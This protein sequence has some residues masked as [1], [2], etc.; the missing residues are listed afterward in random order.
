MHKF[1]I[2][3]ACALAPAAAQAQNMPV[4]EFLQRSDAASA[5]RISGDTPEYQRLARE[6][7]DSARLARNE[8][9]IARRQNREPLACLRP[10]VRATTQAEL[11]AHL[12]SIP[13]AEAQ[14][15]TVHQAYMQL[16]SRKFPC[17]RG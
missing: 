15:T 17:R 7:N 3:L 5:A 9:R 13:A 2:V 10:G 14:T 16:M 8:R 11:F 4:A 1:L 6:L 12:R